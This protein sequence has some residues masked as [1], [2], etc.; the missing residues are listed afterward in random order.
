MNIK[1]M[2]LPE[3]TAALKELGLTLADA[4]QLEQSWKEAEVEA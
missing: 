1:A 2:T 3:L 4:A